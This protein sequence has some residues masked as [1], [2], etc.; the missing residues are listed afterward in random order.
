MVMPPI[1]PMIQLLGSCLG[2]EGSTLNSGPSAAA[3][4]EVARTPNAAP[5]PSRKALERCFIDASRNIWRRKQHALPSCFCTAERSLR[6]HVRRE[7]LDSLTGVDFAGIEI[8]F[9]I[10]RHH[11]HPMELAGLAAAMAECIHHHAIGAPDHAH[12]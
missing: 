2:Q 9:G 10:E 1:C 6:R 4:R 7:F 5:R 11:M 8:A 12:I 3:G